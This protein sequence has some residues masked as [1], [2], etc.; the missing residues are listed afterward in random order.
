[1]EIA[2]GKMKTKAMTAMTVLKDLKGRERDLP[3]SP[4]LVRAGEAG[5]D[6]GSGMDGA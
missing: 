5:D 4:R 3:L 2:M 1:M 6:K